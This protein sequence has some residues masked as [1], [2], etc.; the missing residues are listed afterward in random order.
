MPVVLY[1]IERYANEI[2]PE[3][4]SQVLHI[5]NIAAIKDSS[6]N[7]PDLMAFLDVAGRKP[8]FGVLVGFEEMLSSAVPLGASGCMTA[9]GGIFPEIMAAIFTAARDG[10]TKDAAALQKILAA[11]TNRMRAVFFPYGYKLAME[12][13]GFDMGKYKVIFDETS[14]LQQR[15]SINRAVREALDAY[16][17]F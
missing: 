15:E 8:G 1:N 10:R 9:S 12:A 11:A 13:R 16:R 3:T 14:F 6:G 2:S 4:L 7:L 17:K 5:E